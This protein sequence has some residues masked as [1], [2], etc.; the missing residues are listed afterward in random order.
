MIDLV[1]VSSSKLH[2]VGYDLSAQILRI[3]FN[4]RGIYDY[5]NVPEPTYNELM[6]ATSKSEY[7][8]SHIKGRFIFN[9]IE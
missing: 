8:A 1:R 6:N 5:Y 4:R 9:K 3:K 2:S 7:F